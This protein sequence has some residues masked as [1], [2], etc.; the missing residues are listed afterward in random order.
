LLAHALAENRLTPQGE[1]VWAGLDPADRQ[2]LDRG[3]L[4]ESLVTRLTG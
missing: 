4:D 3:G 2:L 1:D